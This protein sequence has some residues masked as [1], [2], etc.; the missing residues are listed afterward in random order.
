MLLQCPRRATT[1]PQRDAAAPDVQTIAEAGVPG[2]DVT[3]SA[4]KD[5]LA[6][7]GYLA[8]G[9]SPEELEKLLK[10]EIAKWSAVIKSVGIKID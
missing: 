5:K 4:I 7:N 10:L 3:A 2:Y 9:S 1:G 6:K 8:E